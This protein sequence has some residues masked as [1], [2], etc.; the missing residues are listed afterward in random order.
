MNP[1]EYI[2][3]IDAFLVNPE[4]GWTR[5]HLK[6]GLMRIEDLYSEHADF[7]LGDGAAFTFTF[8]GLLSGKG[9]TIHYTEEVTLY[10]E[11]SIERFLSQCYQLLEERLY[12]EG[13]FKGIDTVPT[14][15]K[16][17]SKLKKLLR[18]K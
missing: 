13:K 3:Q 15:E 1:N 16:K 17:P 6:H 9:N 8:G 7:V 10:K 18:R 2:Q 12:R 11:D 4:S 5:L 14:T